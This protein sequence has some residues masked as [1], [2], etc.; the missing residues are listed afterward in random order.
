MSSETGDSGMAQEKETVESDTLMGMGG[1]TEP[2]MP[3]E[4]TQPPTEGRRTQLR[5]VRENLHSLSNDVGDFRRSHEASVGRLEKQVSKLRKDVKAQASGSAKSIE[6]FRKSHSAG[7]KKLERQ[8]E[9]LRKQLADMRRGIAKD[10]AKSKAR[11]EATLSK[12]LAKID[13]KTSKPKASKSKKK[14]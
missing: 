7:S 14:K 2:S 10:A 12:I 1:S 4:P 9:S 3:M 13:R 5:I 8:V 6:D 11:E